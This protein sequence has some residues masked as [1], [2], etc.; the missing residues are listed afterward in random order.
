MHPTSETDFIGRS[1]GFR[2]FLLEAVTLR[3]EP[4]AEAWTSSRSAR[5]DTFQET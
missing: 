4:F 3:L 1:F 5:V 2:D